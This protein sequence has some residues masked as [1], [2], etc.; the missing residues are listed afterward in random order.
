MTDSASSRPSR[1]SRKRRLASASGSEKSEG[2]DSDSSS[3][4]EEH[5]VASRGAGAGVKSAAAR[6]KAATAGSSA[7]ASA[8]AEPKQRRFGVDVWSIP[9]PRLV[10]AAEA[11]RKW[12]SKAKPAVYLDEVYV[13]QAGDVVHYFRSGHVKARL[14]RDPDP[15]RQLLDDSVCIMG[16]DVSAL[17]FRIK[18][19]VQRVT[20]RLWIGRK[21]EDGATELKHCERQFHVVLEVVI[22]ADDCAEFTVVCHSEDQW[23]V[24]DWLYIRNAARASAFMEGG[25]RIKMRFEDSGDAEGDIPKRRLTRGS[26]PC[27]DDEWLAHEV[28]W[29]D[30]STRDGNE[31]DADDGSSNFVSHWEVVVQGED[32]RWLPD[33][34]LPQPMPAAAPLIALIDS[35][36]EHPIGS[37]LFDRPVNLR[38][39][40]EYTDTAGIALPMDLSLIRARLAS[41]YYRSLDAVLSDADLI[42]R[43]AHLYNDEELSNIPAF[44]EAVYCVVNQHIAQLQLQQ[45]GEEEQ[46]MQL[47]LE[48][49][50]ERSI[51]SQELRPTL[52]QFK[53]CL[54][55]LKQCDKFKAF[56]APVDDDEAPG[57]SKIIAHRMD[58]GTMSDKISAREYAP[59]DLHVA[60]SWCNTRCMYASWDDFMADVTLLVENCITYVRSAPS[61]RACLT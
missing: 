18:G 15:A 50:W 3:S 24:P 9:A 57:Y 43:N 58:L 21:L 19:T 1:S 60:A 61:L 35:L 13:P 27:L 39:C 2:D 5:M 38:D 30:D 52:A 4:S 53:K 47:E 56:G 42:A 23:L 59:A 12:L 32:G 36:C 41:G 20:P 11:D 40:P 10:G 33:P 51:W 16:K 45:L 49:S 48:D 25:F 55:K 8:A 29:D 22:K 7:A 26:V 54:S 31:E 28:K 14:K 34:P 44:A 17:P 37:D 46:P 6:P